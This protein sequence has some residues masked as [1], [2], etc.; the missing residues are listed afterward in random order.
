MDVADTI[1]LMDA[2]RIEQVGPPR[3]LYEHPA[4]EF[5][6]GFIGPVN[7]LGDSW[8]RP[9]DIDILL[10]EVDG[11]LEAIIERVVYLGFE[12]RVELMRQDGTNVWAQVPRDEAER[13]ELSQ[14]QIVHTRAR[15]KHVFASAVAEVAPAEAAA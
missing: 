2:G 14:G 15:S 5:V 1:V 4:N 10:D 11:S 3:D 7:R 12:V 8:V 9:H 13:L 6:M